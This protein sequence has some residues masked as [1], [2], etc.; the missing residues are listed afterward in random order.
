MKGESVCSFRLCLFVVSILGLAIVVPNGI[1]NSVSE[2]ECKCNPNVYFTGIT[3]KNADNLY[4]NY[5]IGNATKSL[6]ILVS[7]STFT[8]FDENT[9]NM[10][11]LK[12]NREVK[13]RI[14][15]TSREFEEDMKTSD[16]DIKHL[17]IGNYTM[18]LFMIISDDKMVYLPSMNTM[19]GGTSLMKYSMY[20]HECPSLYYD[21]KAL[22]DY[23]YEIADTFPLYKI[24]R[25][26]IPGYSFPLTHRY[27][28][29]CQNGDKDKGD[30]DEAPE[31]FRFSFSP[32]EMV[33]PGRTSLIDE[34]IQLLDKSDP[35]DV[36]IISPQIFPSTEVQ[37]SSADW[38]R[39]EKAIGR[40]EN[41][42]GLI[43]ICTSNDHLTE[44]NEEF[45][46][47]SYSA[48]S[49]IT[50]DNFDTFG[51]SYIVAADRTVVLPVPFSYL[52]DKKHF[53]QG[54]VIND[55]LVISDVLYIAYQRSDS[56]TK[57][58]IE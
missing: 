50:H 47:F 20:I 40:F 23:Y 57:I 48:P 38:K 12:V 39:I 44:F 18:H 41:T 15:S 22:F 14:L 24:R 13:V 31:F 46:R 30:D 51:S 35:S 49:I 19:G 4:L 29:T 42:N 27:R 54:Y 56:E 10:I 58:F 16:L 5:T 32:A 3:E 25:D 43:E 45:K 55:P 33:P 26:L 52:F 17:E 28:E 8:L 6:D 1:V 53:I 7:N 37:E 34:I 11:K 21:A 2:K 36:H 9:K